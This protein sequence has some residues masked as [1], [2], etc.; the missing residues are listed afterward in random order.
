MRGGNAAPTLP[1]QDK[2]RLSNLSGQRRPQHG[3]AQVA[4]KKFRIRGLFDAVPLEEIVKIGGV[5][6]GEPL[7]QVAWGRV[8]GHRRQ[9]RMMSGQIEQGNLKTLGRRGNPGG[10]NSRTGPRL[11]PGNL[12]QGR[13]RRTSA[14][15]L[16]SA[17]AAGGGAGGGR[18]RGRRTSAWAAGVGAGG[19]LRWWIM[20]RTRVAGRRP[21]LR[22]S[23]R[24]DPDRNPRPASVAPSG[25]RLATNHE[26]RPRCS[27][28]ARPAIRRS[29]GCRSGWPCCLSLSAP[30]R[31]AGRFRLWC[32]AAPNPPP[33]PQRAP[34]TRSRRR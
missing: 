34:C 28:R 12:R 27:F 32:F 6:V 4:V 31:L 18:R 25:L 5:V 16:T 21:S 13:R 20:L 3:E 7:A 30:H 2:S 23:L 11:S 15:A 8:V 9:A 1:S 17:R 10:S 14:W 24:R 19:V 33:P 29:R 26:A 22:Q